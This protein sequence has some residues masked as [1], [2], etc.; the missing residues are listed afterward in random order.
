MGLLE[1]I[2]FA[3]LFLT[4]AWLLYINDMQLRLNS[5][6]IKIF[7]TLVKLKEDKNKEEKTEKD[8]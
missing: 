6:F 3:I 7:N 5:Q 1:S 2:L 8:K 4:N